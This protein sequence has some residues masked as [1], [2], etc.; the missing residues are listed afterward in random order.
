MITMYSSSRPLRN[1]KTRLAEG[2]SAWLTFEF[3]CERGYLFSEYYLAHAVGQLLR[4]EGRTVRAEQTHPTLAIPGRTGRPPSVDFVVY[5]AEMKPMLAVETKWAGFSEVT[6]G[7]L[8][9]DAFRLESF[10]RKT[11]APGL[12]ILGGTIE[13]VHAL[14]NS[15]A[16]KRI[17]EDTDVPLLPLPSKKHRFVLDRSSLPRAVSKHI[18]D[19]VA[20]IN[21]LPPGTISEQLHCERPYSSEQAGRKSMSFCVYVWEVR[22][23]GRTAS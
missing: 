18:H 1:L 15:E 22:S 17:D 12:L 9:W 4:T 5:D 7:A 16:F 14:F 21:G 13:K 8:I 3:K 2:L 19:K 20:K 11:G 10:H 23:R 6:A